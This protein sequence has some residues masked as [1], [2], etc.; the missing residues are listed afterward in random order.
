[1]KGVKAQ[2]KANSEKC[3]SE[4]ASQGNSAQVDT[5]TRVAILD[6]LKLSETITSLCCRESP[7]CAVGGGAVISSFDNLR[8]FTEMKIGVG[9]SLRPYRRRA[10]SGGEAGSPRSGG[11]R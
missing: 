4:S 1:M 5:G 11:L 9:E 7:A 8:V 3:R 6:E 10:E 2:W